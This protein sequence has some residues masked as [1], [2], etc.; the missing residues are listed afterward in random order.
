M[1]DRDRLVALH[2]RAFVCGALVAR[3]A[4]SWRGARDY[5]RRSADRARI[6]ID[7]ATRVTERALRDG[8]L[9]ARSRV[10]RRAA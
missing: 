10:L 7:S 6:P 2:A 5:L 1:T 4:V 9:A 3:H 8:E